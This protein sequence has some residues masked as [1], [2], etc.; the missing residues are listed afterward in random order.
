MMST[1]RRYRKKPDQFV[2]AIQLDLDTEGLTYVKWGARQ[3][4]KRED[5][6]VDNQGGYLFCKQRSLCENLSPGQPRNLYEIRADM[7]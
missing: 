1:R 3:Q 5:C 2:V 7:G 4:C 6:L